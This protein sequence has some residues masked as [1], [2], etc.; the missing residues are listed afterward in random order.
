MPSLAQKI[1]KAKNTAL[2]TIYYGYIPLIFA[3]GYLSVRK[4]FGQLA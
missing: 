2:K 4:Q 1:E 3:L